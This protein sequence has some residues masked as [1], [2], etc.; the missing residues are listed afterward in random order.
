MTKTKKVILFIVEGTS[1]RTALEFILKKIFHKDEVVFHVVGSDI[2][3]AYGS[4]MSNAV[5][6]VWSQVK[7]F[8]NVS[9]LQASDILRIIH[10]IDTDGAYISEE[11]IIQEEGTKGF[12]YK[13]ENIVVHRK[14]E[15]IKRNRR[16][17]NVVNRLIETHTIGRRAIPYQIFYMSCNLEHVLHNKR[18][19]KDWDKTDM[20]DDFLDDYMSHEV[21]FVKFIKNPEFA[22]INDYEQSWAFI[23]E[24]TRS[25]HRHSNLGLIF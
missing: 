11:N 23:K 20:A 22:V 17:S 21:D 8:L 18:K 16:K 13:N 3:S 5:T 24:G 25:L 4:S 14:M 1:D 19:V 10:I 9:K 6:K 15:A 12:V 2:T 7:K